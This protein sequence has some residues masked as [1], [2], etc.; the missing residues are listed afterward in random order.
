MAR[1]DHDNTMLHMAL[2]TSSH[3]LYTKTPGE[4]RSLGP[5]CIHTSDAWGQ[6]LGHITMH[7]CA[8]SR[9]SGR[10]GMEQNCSWS[11]G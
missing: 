8:C 4:I 7:W 3:H 11:Y 2:Y 6:A 10:N 9:Q 1:Q 5:A